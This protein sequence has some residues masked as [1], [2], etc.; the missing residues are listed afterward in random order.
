MTDEAR[1]AGGGLNERIGVP[2]APPPIRP[3][4]GTPFLSFRAGGTHMFRL[5]ASLA[6]GRDRRNGAVKRPLSKKDFGRPKRH[7]FAGHGPI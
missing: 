6:R 2:L 1:V 3:T 4:M 5:R 7:C